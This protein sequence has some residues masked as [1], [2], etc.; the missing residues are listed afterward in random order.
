MDGSVVNQLGVQA[1]WVGWAELKHAYDRYK[2][3]H[4]KVMGVKARPA[5]IYPRLLDESWGWNVL[6]YVFLDW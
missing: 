3:I 4:P 2:L 6:A 5:D 1:R